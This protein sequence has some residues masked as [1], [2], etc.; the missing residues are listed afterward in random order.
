MGH[1]QQQVLPGLL[2]PGLRVLDVGSG[3]QPA[4]NPSKK[5]ALG[6]SIT[7]LDISAAEL[8]LAPVGAYDT[9]IVGDAA[10]VTISG[11]YDLI[12]SHTV[13]EHVHDTDAALANLSA[14]LAPGGVMAHF[15]PCANAPFAVLNR[16]LGGWSSRLLWAVY[17][18][19]RAVAGFPAYYRNCTPSGMRRL[20]EQQGLVVDAAIPYFCSNYGRFL[21]PLHAAELTRQLLCQWLRADNLAETFT[22]VAR[23]PCSGLGQIVL[24]RAA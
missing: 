4:I 22:I 20:C 13:L 1:F 6:L 12:V 16:L 9:L 5:S 3:K 14:A 18:K 2:R 15:M 7:G 24:S 23:K 21:V 8:A 19:S 17:P 11:E 10:T